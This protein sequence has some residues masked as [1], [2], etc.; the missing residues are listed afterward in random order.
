M[1]ELETLRK[2]FVTVLDGMWWGLRDNTGPL[3]MY[4]GYMRGFKEMGSEAAEDAEGKGANSAAKI[5]H[6][7]LTAIGLDTEL[8]QSTIKVR[9][10]PLWNR[11]RE[12]GLEY[13]WHIEEICW[14]PMLEGIGEKVGAKPVIETSLRLIHNEHARLDYK[15]GKAK[16]ALDAG[17]ID[18]AEYEKQISALDEG[19]KKLPE[20]GIYRFE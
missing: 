7:L 15:K 6:T 16:K 2:A 8:E 17:S 11:I 12:R 10:C 14:K 3:S 9:D 13:A 1:S 18:K 19:I 5:A 20:V 4:D